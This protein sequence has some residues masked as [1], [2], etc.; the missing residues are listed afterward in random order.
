MPGTTTSGVAEFCARPIFFIFLLERNNNYCSAIPLTFSETVDCDW[1]DITFSHILA[2]ISS[3][4]CKIRTIVL[5]NNNLTWLG[6]DF[7][8]F[9]LFWQQNFLS[10][11]NSDEKQFTLT[12]WGMKYID[13]SFLPNEAFQLSMTWRRC[14]ALPRATF[15][16][17]ALLIRRL[18]M[19]H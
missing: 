12:I 13:C 11:Q 5:H 17:Q 16:Q 3:H 2:I 10:V 14:N 9:D 7:G 6:P 8:L 15:M 4:S 18:T 1:L 19:K